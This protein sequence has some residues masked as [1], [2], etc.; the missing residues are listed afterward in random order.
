MTSNKLHIGIHNNSQ[1]LVDVGM[2]DLHIGLI[3][4]AY[5]KTIDTTPWQETKF[6]KQQ[7]TTQTKKAISWGKKNLPFNQTVTLDEIH[8]AEGPFVISEMIVQWPY[9]EKVV[10]QGV[11][12]TVST[13][14]LHHFR[15][16][17]FKPGLFK[18]LF[19]RIPSHPLYN[20]IINERKKWCRQSKDY[21]TLRRLRDT[22]LI[23]R[24]S[25]R[26]PYNVYKLWYSKGAMI[27]PEKSG[28]FVGREL[29]LDFKEEA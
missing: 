16:W 1:V 22:F 6:G 24:P 5:S 23:N 8:E 19:D 25:Q 12:Q 14:C 15:K 17:P 20:R 26:V 3:R 7:T 11:P 4:G 28:S 13:I 10:V 29:K 2:G 27:L 9:E 21:E 18:R